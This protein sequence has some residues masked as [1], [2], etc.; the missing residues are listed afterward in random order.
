MSESLIIKD[1]S[2]NIK[3]LQVDSGSSGY[4]SNHTL[5]PASNTTD[6]KSFYIDGP[7]GWSWDSELSGTAALC[8]KNNSRKGIVIHNNSID[9]TFYILLGNMT[10]TSSYCGFDTIDDIEQ[11]PSKYSFLLEAGGTYFADY[12]TCGLAHSMYIPSS[13]AISEPSSVKLT[14]T[15][16]Y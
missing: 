3:S 13:S 14:I 1:G 5:V 7:N 16:I 4:I 11:P 10:D 6:I 8:Y 9:S 15:E 2:G 12:L